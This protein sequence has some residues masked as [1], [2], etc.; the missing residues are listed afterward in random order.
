MKNL[1]NS[2][3]KVQ[4]D[5]YPYGSLRATAFFSLEFQPKKGFRSVFQTINP[6]TNRLN[7]PKK[8]TYN[9]FMYLYTEEETGHTKTGV[10]STNGTEA[11]MK[12]AEFLEVNS[13]AVGLTTAQISW[14]GGGIYQS[15]VLSAAWMSVN[16]EEGKEYLKPFVLEAKKG[17]TTGEMDFS[18]F[19]IDLEKYNSYFGR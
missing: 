18:K 8:S 1:L 9:D 11:I 5:N 16:K 3:T 10:F 7:N 6:K 13:E 2:A 17:A 19:K 14:L 4:N 15:L 12:L